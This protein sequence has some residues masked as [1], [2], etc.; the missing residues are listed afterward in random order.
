MS[1]IIHKIT[2][3]GREF[4]IQ[5]EVIPGPE[6]KVRTLVYDGGRLVTTREIPLEGT[7]KTKGQVETEATEQ[8]RRIMDTLIS[9]AAELQATKTGRPAPPPPRAAAAPPPP[10]PAHRV[11]PPPRAPPPAAPVAKGM[12]RP[13]I[14]PDSPL[15]MAVAIRR[16]IGPFSQAFALPAPTTAEGFERALEAAEAAIDEI[17]K[18]P[19]YEFI[20]LD[21]QLTFI[22][23]RGQLATWRLSQRDIT[24]A[25]EIWPSVERFAYHLQKLNHRGDLVAFDHKLLTW[26]MSRL[27]SGTI[28]D[29]LVD[30]LQG[31][32]GRD[33]ELDHLLANP[34]EMDQVGL[35]EVLLRLIDQTLV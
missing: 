2:L 14:E 25:T 13:E 30:G 10:P 16:I 23:L 32:A 20:R 15:E 24:V 22:A 5:T 27:G 4:T 3:L 1:G 34:D 19:E 29:E 17:M 31:L 35:L 6:G 28:D 33:A 21:E 12:P 9:R 26:A 7:T 11:A 18:A 8:H